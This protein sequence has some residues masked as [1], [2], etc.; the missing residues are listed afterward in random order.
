M[1]LV[2]HVHRVMA[3]RFQNVNTNDGPEMRTWVRIKI[4]LQIEAIHLPREASASRVST[5]G[6]ARRATPHMPVP[7]PRVQQSRDPP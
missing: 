2:H 6:L 1:D 4:P 7:Q 5:P 3:E